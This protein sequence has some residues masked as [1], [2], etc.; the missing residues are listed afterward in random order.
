[1]PTQDPTPDELAAIIAAVEAT[2]PPST[3]APGAVSTPPS[4]R[5]AGRWWTKPIPTRRDRPWT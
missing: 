2:W 5:F 1:M 4:W 3:S